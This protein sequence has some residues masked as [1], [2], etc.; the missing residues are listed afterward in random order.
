MSVSIASST[1][2]ISPHILTGLFADL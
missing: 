1:P 2:A